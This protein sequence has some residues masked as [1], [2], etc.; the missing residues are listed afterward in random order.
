[1]PLDPKHITTLADATKFYYSD[2]E[3]MELCT[4]FEVD[5]SYHLLSGVP[6]LAWGRSLLQNIDQG[7]NRRFLRALVGSL[8]SR[9]REA[10]ANNG[11]DK[12][13][14]HQSMCDMISSLE[15]EL[16]QGGIPEDLSHP[17][18]SPS[19]AWEEAREFLARAGTEIT[20]VDDRLGI[21]T[22]DCLT[23]VRQHIRILTTAPSD[24]PEED[25]QGAMKEFRAKDHFLSVRCLPMLHDRYI[26]FNNRCWLAGSSLSRV[27]EKGFNVI[28]IVDVKKQIYAEISNRWEKAAPL[29]V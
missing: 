13:V 18:K 25:I 29:E 7:N 26:L 16:L 6:H 8:L 1:M 3:L 5:L 2:S 10:L 12:R 20:I 21:N 22:F 9:A 24:Q 4:A 15:N 17:V 19:T 11:Y 28:E 27:G 14:H 23:D